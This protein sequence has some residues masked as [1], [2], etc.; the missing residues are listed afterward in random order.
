MKAIV[1]TDLSFGDS[2][3]GSIVDALVR[4]YDSKLVVRATGGCQAS[5]AVARPDGGY[6]KFAQWGSGTFSGAF[7]YLDRNMIIDP[8]AM[9]L[10]AIQ[11]V[12]AGVKDPYSLLRVHPKCL[13][14][15]PVHQFLNRNDATNLD[16]GTCG[17]GIG[18]TRKY[19]LDYGEAAI[20]ACDLMQSWRPIL[21]SKLNL[22]LQRTEL[23]REFSP[24]AVADRLL[25]SA[26]HLSSCIRGYSFP[27]DI[28]GETVIFEGAQG[29]LIDQRYGCHPHTT[30]S[31]V[32][33]RPVMDLLA[34]LPQFTSVRNIGVIRAY[35]TRHGSGPLPTETDEPIFDDMIDPNNQYNEY[36]GDMRFGW[37]DL[38]LLKY[39]LKASPCDSLAVNHVDQIEDKTLHLRT[40]CCITRLWEVERTMPPSEW[41]A[42]PWVEIFNAIDN[43]C[44]IRIIGR[45]PKASDKTF[46]EK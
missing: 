6:H 40:N 45:G 38:A 8:L 4:K 30:W 1:V 14:S 7:T 20:T 13:V 3:K 23:D 24:Y 33:N 42:L 39:A 17:M 37:P 26:Y 32:T 34:S 21:I 16:N 27:Q 43:H 46:L 35:M 31:D 12:S 29:V 41:T 19:W 36:Q 11:L 9:Q 2:G 44:P 25:S 5:H 15:T 22:L 28:P 10:E 18:A